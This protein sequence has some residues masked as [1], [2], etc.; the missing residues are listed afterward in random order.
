[1]F[2]MNSKPHLPLNTI[3]KRARER[4]VYIFFDPDT[5]NWVS[6]NE[7]GREVLELCNGERTVYEIC[8]VLSKK[9]PWT[10]NFSNDVLEFLNKIAAKD[11][12]SDKPFSPPKTITTRASVLK[13]LW[14]HVTNK[15]NMR[16]LHCH[17]DA[18]NR[19]E[20]ELEKE[21]IFGIIDQF[22]QLGGEN[23][24]ISG[25]E[26]L[27]RSELTDILAYANRKEIRIL[28]V[29]TN[30]TLID[31][32]IARCFKELNVYVQVSLDGATPET[33][34]AIRGKG[35]YERA[36]EGI[37][38]LLKAR[39]ST[40]IGMTLMKP[41]TKEI[42]E[43]ANLCKTLGIP[44]FHVGLLQPKGRA[45]RNEDIL[46]LSNRE[47]LAAWKDINDVSKEKGIRIDI[48]E[49]VNKYLT[50]RIK[51]D[52]CGAGTSI[53]SIS[54]DGV[55]YPCAGL[56]DPDFMAGNARSRTLKDIWK[57]SEILRQLRHLHVTQIPE[58]KRCDLRYI[59][60]GGCH[61]FR[62]YQKGKLLTTHPY[63]KVYK[64]L[65]WEILRDLACEKRA[66]PD[67]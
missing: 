3:C 65:Y 32:E 28:R 55:V 64:K 54:A 7:D 14:I 12:L 60:G 57:N 19:F 52:F 11:F 41:N 22:V 18:G 5:P 58:C 46:R 39:V 16:C 13:E 1:M 38:E 47:L 29:V 27:C 10:E 66:F 20:S 37:A 43:M 2:H 63:C 25:G 21:E 61:V 45:K 36:M 40:T 4:G 34:D 31:G 62:Y 9:A 35:N 56:H 23:L 33:N 67:Q 51:N 53:L 48:E 26:P 15:C 24:T 42:F 6:V 44:K 59:C 8:E 49:G 50:K 17:L 30:G